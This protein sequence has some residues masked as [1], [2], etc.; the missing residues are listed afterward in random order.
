MDKPYV[1]IETNANLEEIRTVFASDSVYIAEALLYHTF[2]NES[3]YI[4]D[5]M[6]VDRSNNN[7][8]LAKAFTLATTKIRN[9]LEDRNPYV[10]I[11][12]GE[13]VG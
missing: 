4:V 9:G 13:M 3:N 5:Y 6:L 1:V 8:V 7:E 10:G 2:I 12:S 11:L